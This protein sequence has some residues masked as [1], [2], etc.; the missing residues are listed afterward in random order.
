MST[1][2]A[3]FADLEDQVI[4]VL[5]DLLADEE[6]TVGVLPD[7]WRNP[8]EPTPQLP[9]VQVAWD[10]TRNVRQVL[11]L[12]TIRVTAWAPDGRPDESKRLALL[13]EGLLLQRPEARPLTGILP[14]RDPDNHAEIASFTVRWAARSTPIP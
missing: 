6:C 11:A 14:A 8:T 5:E 3:Q 12:A 4:G 2:S 7:G 9:H 1:P 10:G 13:A